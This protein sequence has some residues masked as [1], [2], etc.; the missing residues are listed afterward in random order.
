M[1]IY[2]N[3]SGTILV[4]HYKR[5]G[6]YTMPKHH[7]HDVYELY[8]LFTGERHF[9]IRDRSYRIESGCFVFVEKEELHKTIDAE[10]PNHERLV[11]NFSSELL[12]QFPLHGRSGVIMLPP[13]MQYKGEA[14]VREIIA[15]AQSTAEG[16]DLMLEA[17]LKQLLLLL[18]RTQ[19]EQPSHEEE[20]SSVHQTISK[21]A[22]YV[23]SHYD[24]PLRLNDVASRFYI[25]SY[26]LSRKFKEC[27]GFGFSEYV[28]LVRVREAQRLLRETELKMIEIAEQ[29]GIE[30]VANFYKLFKA[31]NGCSPLQYRK[32]QKA[33][34]PR[35][36]LL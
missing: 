3:S 29:V 27:T 23:G 22:A 19:K 28:Q 6:F 21:I 36:K 16:R 30:S 24:E 8:Y 32:R 25:S 10:L 13:Q 26:Y 14:L 17:L 34:S 11:I 12:T 7:A 1:G 9:F 20:T 35:I 2:Y 18:F 31:T 5:E 4:D 33:A 15:E